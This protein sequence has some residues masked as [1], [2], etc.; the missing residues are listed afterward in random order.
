M[1]E[2]ALTLSC[3]FLL[4]FLVSACISC[5]FHN[6]NTYCDVFLMTNIFFF[7]SR[8]NAVYFLLPLNDVEFSDC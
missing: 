7:P 6:H 4:S 2:M 1:V 3:T 5:C 8:H